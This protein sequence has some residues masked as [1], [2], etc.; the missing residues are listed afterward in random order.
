MDNIHSTLSGAEPP[1][2]LHVIC[3][4]AALSIGAIQISMRKGTF[5]HVFLGRVWV[6]LM[7]VVAMSSFFIYELKVWGNYSPIHLLSAWTVI[8][9]AV[10]IYFAR[11]GDIKRHK[12]VMTLLFYLALVLTGAFTLLPGRL[13]HTMVFL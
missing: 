4:I 6:A 11:K 2:P 13:M 5:V 10:G 7:M 3:A 1:T 8:S 12:L 9:L